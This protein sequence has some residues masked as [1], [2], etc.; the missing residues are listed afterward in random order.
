[1]CCRNYK[2]ANNTTT[3]VKKSFWPT[4]SYACGPV[5]DQEK[6]FRHC[7]SPAHRHRHAGCCTNAPN[8]VRG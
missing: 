7:P 1:M 2:C 3:L 4:A 5:K 6:D 8:Q